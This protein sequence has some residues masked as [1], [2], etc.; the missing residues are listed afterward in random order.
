MTMQCWT[1]IYYTGAQTARGYVVA[2]NKKAAE[3]RA[4]QRYG[5]YKRVLAPGNQNLHT[6]H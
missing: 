5:T 6:T 4:A 2:G 3:R 1:V